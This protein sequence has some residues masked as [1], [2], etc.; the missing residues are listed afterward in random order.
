MKLGIVYSMS[1]ETQRLESKILNFSPCATRGA[2][3]NLAQSEEMTYTPTGVL[4]D[5]TF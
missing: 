3:P 5:I 1:L 4:Y 2:T